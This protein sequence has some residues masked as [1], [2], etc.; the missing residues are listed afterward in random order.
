MDKDKIDFSDDE[1][2]EPEEIQMNEFPE[3]DEMD[4]E[5]RAYIYNL[6]VNKSYPEHNL[7]EEFSVGTKKKKKRER[8]RK[9]KQ[10]IQIGLEQTYDYQKTE[11]VLKT[12]VTGN[13]LLSVHNG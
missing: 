4:D 9:E 6:T 7:T 3:E 8:K 11:N 13:I 2:E 12:G 1:E 10:F 5:M